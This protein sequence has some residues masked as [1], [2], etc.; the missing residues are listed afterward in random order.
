[1]KQL[2]YNKEAVLAAMR[3]QGN[4]DFSEASSVRVTI[5]A[6]AGWLI[7]DLFDLEVREAG[8][9]KVRISVPDVVEMRSL[10]AEARPTAP[11]SHKRS[12][13]AFLNE[14]EAQLVN[15]VTQRRLEVQN[16]YAYLL[17][18]NFSNRPNEGGAGY[19]EQD[20]PLCPQGLDELIAA[21]NRNTAI[22][23]SGYKWRNGLQNGRD[24]ALLSSDLY[25]EEA[26]HTTEAH[27]FTV[28]VNAV[29]MVD[30]QGEL[31]TKH[32]MEMVQ[33]H[34]SQVGQAI[35]SYCRRN[36]PKVINFS[37]TEGLTIA[38]AMAQTKLHL[39]LAKSSQML[40]DAITKREAELKALGFDI[41]ITYAEPEALAS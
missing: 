25:N 29:A 11:T 3:E 23:M 40:H 16:R 26:R 21:Y 2:S 14:M 10:I 37:T 38:R 7:G 39:I 17:M 20:Y 34:S 22:L 33:D 28:R 18:N 1:M 9:R 13:T 30:E 19:I 12:L 27:G 6:T 8:N 4:A 31:I 15:G 36:A 5:G 24:V 35:I 41:Q 32:E